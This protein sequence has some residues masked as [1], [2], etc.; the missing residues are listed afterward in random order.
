M[1]PWLSNRICTKLGHLEYLDIGAKPAYV[2][3]PK[4]CFVSMHRHSKE[5][6]RPKNS[7]LL[8]VFGPKKI[9]GRGTNFLGVPA[10]PITARTTTAVEDLVKM[11]PAVSENRGA[12]KK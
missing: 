8:P 9:S 1:P 5:S 11:P 2:I 6:H 12:I 10:I 4:I 7:P 3:L